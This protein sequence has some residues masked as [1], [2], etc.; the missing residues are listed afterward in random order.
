MVALICDI[1]GGNLV[2]DANGEFAVCESC[3]MKH[4]KDRV[5]AKVQE[6]KGV[7]EVTKGEAEKERLLNNANTFMNLGELSNAENILIKLIDDYP[8][9][10]N[11]RL[12]YVKLCFLKLDPRFSK[13][14]LESHSDSRDTFKVYNSLLNAIDLCKK[15]DNGFI[16]GIDKMWEEYEK[17]NKKFVENINRDIFPLYNIWDFLMLNHDKHARENNLCYIPKGLHIPIEKF[18]KNA[19]ELMK[20]IENGKIM[21]I[22]SIATKCFCP[23]FDYVTVGKFPYMLVELKNEGGNWYHASID[24]EYISG[25][26]IEYLSN[27][28]AVCRCNF[29]AP[30]SIRNFSHVYIRFQTTFNVDELVNLINQTPT[31]EE[32]IL[33]EKE[34]LRFERKKH[35]LC[36]HCGGTFKGVFKKCCSVCSKP[37]DY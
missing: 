17:R 18:Q 33:T 31:P 1:C 32:Q 6:I 36:Q 30:E 16:A 10:I 3:G 19:N 5:K 34:N 37:K 23:E 25:V 24:K 29:S 15:I 27:T 13:Q 12:A 7:V 28:E 21:N 20:K 9:D 26:F 2:M 8:D 14:D 11:C 22:F 35:N 4:S